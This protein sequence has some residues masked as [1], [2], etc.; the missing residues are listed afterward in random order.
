[1]VITF[2]AKISKV[3]SAAGCYR[4]L[5]KTCTIKRRT[6]KV[7]KPKTVKLPDPRQI[8]LGSLA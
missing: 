7:A 6:Y 8:K 1:M 3:F 5:K 2:K 4:N